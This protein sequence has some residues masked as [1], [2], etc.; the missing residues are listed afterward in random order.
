MSKTQRKP[1]KAEGL[2]VSG[3]EQS[4]K[5]Q[6]IT[7]CIC[8]TRGGV[9]GALAEG[10]ELDETG[11]RSVSR[12]RQASGVTR[13]VGVWSAWR[14]TNVSRSPNLCKDAYILSTLFF[15]WPRTRRANIVRQNG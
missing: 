15:M 3:R 2:E 12:L 11:M 6:P 4:A 8:T 5:P 7:L 9:Y 14:E 10:F 1:C 13:D